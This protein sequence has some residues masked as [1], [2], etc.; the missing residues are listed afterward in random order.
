MLGSLRDVLFQ[1]IAE[2]FFTLVTVQVPT[3]E[4]FW[5]PNGH[6]I[7]LMFLPNTEYEVVSKSFQ[8]GCLE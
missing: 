2:E 8:I 4:S 3:P 7:L 5:L 1:H 6:L